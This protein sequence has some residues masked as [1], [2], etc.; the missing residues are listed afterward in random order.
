MSDEVNKS[1][2]T[3]ELRREKNPI[4][5]RGGS[6]A[7]EKYLHITARLERHIVRHIGH[8]GML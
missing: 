6:A 8:R 3:I 2:Q 5:G 4:K 7:N 1:T